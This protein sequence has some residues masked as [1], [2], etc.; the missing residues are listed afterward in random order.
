[1][2][3][4]MILAHLGLLR[5]AEFTVNST[6][7]HEIHLSLSSISFHVNEAGTKYFKSPYYAIIN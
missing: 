2:W 1:M 5:A 7:D 6:Y 4:A 3:A